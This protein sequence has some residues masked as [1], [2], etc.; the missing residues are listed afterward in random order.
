MSDVLFYKGS[1]EFAADQVATC[2]PQCEAQLTLHQP[3][4][5]LPDRLLA[6]CDE[7]KSWYL[8]DSQAEALTALPGGTKRGGKRGLAW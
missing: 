4:L 6:I 5:E 8:T 3:D 7:C 1:G 2:C